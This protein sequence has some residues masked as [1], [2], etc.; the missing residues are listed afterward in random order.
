MKQVSFQSSNIER[1]SQYSLDL[2]R[3][4]AL[5]LLH[6]SNGSEV[7][8]PSI[9]NH[10]LAVTRAASEAVANVCLDTPPV[11]SSGSDIII[12]LDFALAE[13]LKKD[14]W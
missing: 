2:S 8:S 9:S 14:R 6:E 13:L 10:H 3:D 5:L 7:R 4:C 12:V 1:W 11:S